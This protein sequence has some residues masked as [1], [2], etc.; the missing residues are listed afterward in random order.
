MPMRRGLVLL[1]LLPALA[2][3]GAAA[4]TPD[5]Q[6]PVGTWQTVDDHTGKPAGAV[7]IFEIQGRLYGDIA[8]ILDGRYD[9]RPAERHRLPMHDAPHGWRPEAGRARLHRHQPVRAQ[10]DLDQGGVTKARL[11]QP[12]VCETESTVPS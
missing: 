8:R 2:I 9:P 7:R 10:P 5:L 1:A 6:S 11:L 12:H 4:Q 3:F